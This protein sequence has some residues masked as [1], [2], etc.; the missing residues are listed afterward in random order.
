MPP[1]TRRKPI[2]PHLSYVTGFFAVAGALCFVL[3]ST[4]Y[5]I[6]YRRFGIS[7]PDVDLGYSDIV[8]HSW[9]SIAWIG[10]ALFVLTFLLPI[11]HLAWDRIKGKES[12]ELQLLPHWCNAAILLATLSAA[13]LIGVYMITDAADQA[14][15]GWA[16]RPVRDPY[17]GL[18]LLDV[19]AQPVS[20]IVSVTEAKTRIPTPGLTYLGNSDRS[21]VLYCIR[22]NRILR[23]SMERFAL[24]TSPFTDKASRDGKSCGPAVAVADH[25]TSPPT[26]NPPRA[27]Q[28]RGGK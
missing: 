8:T 2:T 20:E 5:G 24:R 11:L 17:F 25:P 14:E 22:D 18:M 26:P 16:V 19:H 27:S 3:F 12:P 15:D 1:N 10:V 7:P 6:F 13:G 9:G 4:C 21:F 28:G 23:I